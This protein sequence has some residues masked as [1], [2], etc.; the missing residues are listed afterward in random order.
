MKPLEA[1][2]YHPG[3][4]ASSAEEDPQAFLGSL[5]SFMGSKKAATK[6]VCVK[7]MYSNVVG[8]CRKI[9]SDIAAEEDYASPQMARLQVLMEEILNDRSS[10]PAEHAEPLHSADG[11]E[12]ENT[13][14]RLLRKRK[15]RPHISSSVYLS[16]QYYNPVFPLHSRLFLTYTSCTQQIGFAKGTSRFNI[17]GQPQIFQTAN[18]QDEQKIK[19]FWGGERDG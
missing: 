2:S 11:E 6:V 18:C 19:F 3:L 17:V 1:S 4:L 13:L 12:Q 5:E 8:K 10:Q 7:R 14:D 9:C 15:S 16:T